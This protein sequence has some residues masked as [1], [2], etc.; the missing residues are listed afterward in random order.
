MPVITGLY[1]YPIKGLSPQPIETIRISAGQPFPFDRVFALARPNV[2]IDVAAPRWSKKGLFLMLMLDETLA[3]VRTHLDID[4]MQLTVLR[5]D[6]L[7]G[8]GGAPAE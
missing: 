4:T 2:P 3:Q 8:D 6:A 7:F 5:E 1:R